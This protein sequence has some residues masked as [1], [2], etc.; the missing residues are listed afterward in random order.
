VNV[1]A[2]P[3]DVVVTVRVTD[4]TGAAAPTLVL[5]SDQTAQSL[6][7]G[8]MTLLSGSA[9]DGTY[10]RTVSIPATAATGPWT[11]MINPLADTL[12]NTETTSHAHPQKLT[13][14]DVTGVTVPGAPT[15][16][17]AVA[18]NGSALVSWSA[19]ASTGGAAISGYTV[20]A[21]PGGRTCTAVGLSCTVTGLTNGTGYTFTVTATNSAGTGPGSTPSASVAPAFVPNG[22]GFTAVSPRRVLDTRTGVGAP[23]AKVGAR[24]TVTV[25]IAG[26]PVGTTAV[27]LN[28]TATRPTATSYVSVYPGGTALPGASNLNVVAGQ[29][30]ANQV[31]VALGSGNRVTLYNYAGT[32]DLV[33]DLSG[34]YTG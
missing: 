6:G 4:A 30:I 12:G 24:R 9:K 21:S 14:T 29:T 31:T 18:G 26:L 13:V 19:P 20:T 16:V 34:Y 22:S 8:A 11:V 17:L 15:A 3:V 2:G 23:L 27:T 28:V 33:V 10:Q 32:I 5:T 25:A 1:H 7:A